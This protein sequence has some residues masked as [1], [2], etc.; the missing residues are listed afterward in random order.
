VTGED[1]FQA[2]GRRLFSSSETGRTYASDTGRVVEYTTGDDRALPEGRFAVAVYADNED[3]PVTASMVLDDG[4]IEGRSF[5]ALGTGAV[6]ARIGNE[7]VVIVASGAQP[8][9]CTLRECTGAS[10]ATDIPLG[11][12]GPLVG[13]VP[14]GQGFIVIHTGGLIPVDL[15]GNNPVS[16]RLGAT[17]STPLLLN[18]CALLGIDEPG[19]DGFIRKVTPTGLTPSGITARARGDLTVIARFDSSRLVAAGRDGVLQL[20]AV[21]SDSALC[22]P[23][24]AVAPPT[25]IGPDRPLVEYTA[26]TVAGGNLAVGTSRGEVWTVPGAP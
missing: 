4:T 2:T 12:C 16:R 20:T 7:H 23:T 17:Q 24:T 25:P 18:G 1:P 26:V 9:T 15:P 14:E 11:G 22:A 21:A 5:S 6:A 13:V 10:C 8:G 19:D 3:S